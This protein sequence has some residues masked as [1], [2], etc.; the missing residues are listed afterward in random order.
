LFFEYLVVTSI[1]QRANCSVQNIPFINEQ[2]A[3][4]HNKEES[5]EKILVYEFN[6]IYDK[7][8]EDITNK[9]IDELA[10]DIQ[11]LSS[12]TLARTKG[13][14]IQNVLPHRN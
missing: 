8:V 7:M 13:A 9:T 2:L 5:C 12:T 1:A 6:V 3:H 4:D 14:D 11:R 10:S